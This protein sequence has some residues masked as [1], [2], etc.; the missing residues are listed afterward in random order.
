[1]TTLIVNRLQ[2]NDESALDECYRQLGP[3]VRSYVGHFVPRD[4]VEDV[5]QQV[6]FELWRSRERVD[7]ERSLEA[8]ILGIARKRSIDLLRRR[9]NIVVDVEQ[10]RGLVGEDG[11]ELADR[12]AWAGEIRRALAILPEEQRESLELAYFEDQTQTQIAQRLGVPLGTVKARMARGV[13]RLAA[14]IQ[15]GEEQ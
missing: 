15:R 2:E 1:M 12:L 11:R 8:F 5:V 14:E 4:D 3:L 9:R 7:P 13:R 6:F 10:I